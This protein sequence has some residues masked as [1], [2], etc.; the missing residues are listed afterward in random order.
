M[1]EEI[2]EECFQEPIPEFGMIE[3]LCRHCW[4]HVHDQDPSTGRPPKRCN[5]CEGVKLRSYKNPN[6]TVCAC[7]ADEYTP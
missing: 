4:A 2:C 7:N 1:D 3:D 5:Q 6:V